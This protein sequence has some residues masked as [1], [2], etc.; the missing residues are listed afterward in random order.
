MTAT[1][2]RIAARNETFPAE[3]RHP[4][5]F[6][7]VAPVAAEAEILLGNNWSLYCLDLA[8]GR[9]LFVELPPGIDLSAAPFVYS[10]QFQA[11][12][13]AAT[14]P[15]DLLLQLAAASAD[16]PDIALL[17]STG[18]CGSTYASRVLAQIPGVW[19]LSEPDW[20]TNLAFARFDLED[21]TRDALISACVRLTC[22]PPKAADVRTVVFKPRSEMMCQAAAYTGVVGP[23]RTVFLYRD[24]FGYANSLYRFAQRV[25]G[26]KDPAPGTA[27]WKVARDMSTI[28]APQ[29]V[30]PEFFPES[31]RIEL[32]DLIAV[33]WALRI[34]A[35]QDAAKRGLSAVPLHYDDLVADPGAGMRQLLTGCGIDPAHADIAAI[36]FAGDAHAGS[37]GANTFAAAD[38]SP[39]QHHRVADLVSGW[40]LSDFA[41]DRLLPSGTPGT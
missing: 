2:Y 38:I 40:G 11:A 36:S 5:Q 8:G 7:L 31:A 23:A 30:L 28:S 27:P 14:V 34:S 20:F 18:R 37:A 33:A 41:S 3:V 6:D 13:R 16:P 1:V 39:E 15:L 32:I 29:H 17:L 35:Y 26:V 24:C 10:A 25:S 21:G 19:S 22:Q 9:A 4:G 12:I